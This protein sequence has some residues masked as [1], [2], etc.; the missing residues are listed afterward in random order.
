MARSARTRGGLDEV[1]VLGYEK[2][3]P[4]GFPF[5]DCQ[6]KPVDTMD[7]W[8]WPRPAYANAAFTMLLWGL[9]REICERIVDDVAKWEWDC[10]MNPVGLE[11]WLEDDD[12]E[13]IEWCIE[14]GSGPPARSYGRWTGLH[15]AGSP[16]LEWGMDRR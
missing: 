14:T 13:M 11:W 3:R 4:V 8:A 7:A 9:P 15:G 2:Q 1:A 5:A 6:R 10:Y 12:G 16:P